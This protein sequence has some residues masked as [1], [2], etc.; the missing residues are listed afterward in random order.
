MNNNK[1]N[2]DKNCFVYA[3]YCKETGMTKIGKTTRFKQRM[4]E[5]QG[6]SS[7]KLQLILKV[8]AGPKFRNKII[9]KI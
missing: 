8:C 3:L 9:P 5:I 2:N 1:G 6:M 4:K 7:G